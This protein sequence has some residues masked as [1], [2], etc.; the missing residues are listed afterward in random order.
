MT[1]DNAAVKGSQFPFSLSLER[2]LGVPAWLP[3][4]TSIVAVIVA[5]IL[6]GIVILP[7][8]SRSNHTSSSS[9]PRSAA[10][11]FSMIRW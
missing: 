8:V 11:A 1:T 3:A 6:G 4:A 7:A 10:R 9:R 2:R 5:L